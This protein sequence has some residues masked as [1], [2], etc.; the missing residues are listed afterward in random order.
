VKT[1]A[2]APAFLTEALAATPEGPLVV[3][4]RAPVCDG[5]E[6]L[7]RARRGD[8]WL[9]SRTEREVPEI[10][11]GLGAARRVPLAGS[12]RMATLASAVTA[13]PPWKVVAHAAAAPSLTRR[14]PLAFVGLAFD[15]AA[16]D[17]ETWQSHGGGAL[18]TPRWTYLR[19]GDE[20]VL[21]WACLDR[22]AGQANVAA[23]ELEALLAALAAPMR[24]RGRPNNP[25]VTQTR[26]SLASWIDHVEAARR[27]IDEGSLRKV[28]A[29]RRTSVSTAHDIAAEDVLE[30]LPADGAMRYLVRLGGATLVGATPER[31]F[32]KRGSRIS[33][34]AL[35]GTRARSTSSAAQG[36]LESAKDLDEHE[37]VVS[38]ISASLRALGATVEVEARAH[39]KQVAN[40]VHLRTGIEAVL[41]EGSS[42]DATQVLAALHPTPA[43]GGWPREAALGFIRAH[44]PS[45]GWYA[46]PLGWIDATGDADVHVALRCALL[47]GA[48][49]WVFA[50]GGIVASSDAA[51]EWDETALK[52]APLLSALGAAPEP[53]SRDV[54][55]ETRVREGE[56]RSLEARQ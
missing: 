13:G 21:A 45:R 49:A 52:M 15:A 10:H 31:L 7:R 33:T 22:W 19:S 38:A 42:T 28:V 53:R 54:S 12:D 32:S 29:A 26:S 39:I 37:P 17:E 4:V 40:L 25:V 46:G 30:G 55:P 11:L 47:R 43:V 24:S 44:E 56:P 5:T 3:V 9:L 18:V 41:P 23:G 36:L 50:G 27:T 48:R 14:L 1:E 35:A 51:A 20:A 2:D 16:S 34:E 8:A 6:A